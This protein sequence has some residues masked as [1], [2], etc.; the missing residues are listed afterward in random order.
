MNRFSP[1]PVFLAV[2][3]SG[4]MVLSACE[5]QKPDSPQPVIPGNRKSPIAIS[6]VK[7]NGT[8]IKV[9]Y[10]Q[11]YRKGRSIFGDWEPY[12]EVWRTG[13]NEA[14]EITITNTILMG[15]EPISAGTYTLFTIPYPDK[16]TLI[17][18]STLGQWGAFEYNSAT[19]YK[20]MDFPVIPLEDPVEAFTIEFSE[21][22][23]DLTTMSL[24][25]DTVRV[26][27]PI[28]FY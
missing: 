15:N 6:S 9:V 4:L 28:R 17:L 23:T 5:R 24:S 22:N 20:R 13:A 3:L 14:T 25:W 2:L 26:E 8:Y 10:G 27:V 11:P 7:E 19:D 12:G 16:W 18:N 21:V 1:L